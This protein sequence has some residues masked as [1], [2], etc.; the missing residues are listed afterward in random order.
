MPD[1]PSSD[2]NTPLSWTDKIL[3][4]ASR[5]DKATTGALTAAA[6]SSV[7]LGVAFGTLGWI[8]FLGFTGALIYRGIKYYSERHLREIEQQIQMQERIRLELEAIQKS[9]HLSDE[10]KKQLADNLLKA[11]EVAA[12]DDKLLPP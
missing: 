12:K 7:P 9:P 1:L 8:P 10:Q 2:P 5:I 6:F 3:K 11:S 4:T